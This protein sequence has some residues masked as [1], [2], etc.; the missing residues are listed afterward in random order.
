MTTP[1]PTC[2]PTGGASARSAA[3]LGLVLV[4]FAVP[5]VADAQPSR[6]VPRIGYLHSG[7]ASGALDAFREGLK[8]LGYLEGRNVTID[9]RWAEG[10]YA[11]LPDL[12]AELIRLDADVIVAL[13]TPAARAAKQAT[14]TI[15]IVVGL[16]ADPV[17][18]GIVS[19]G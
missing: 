3:Y 18:S 1:R 12:V 17:G 16:V 9:A 6:K 10:K 15:P 5:F 4:L 11:R 13:T 7:T 14:T 2:S 19:T 8:D